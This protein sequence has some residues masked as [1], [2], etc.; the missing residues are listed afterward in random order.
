MRIVPEPRPLDIDGP[1]RLAEVSDRFNEHPPV[2]ASA[3]R[4]GQVM[5][6]GDRIS[7]LCHVVEN[8]LGGSRPNTR[9]QME[10]AE[11]GDAVA[12]IFDEPQQRKHV[13]HMRSIEKL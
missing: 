3:R 5:E 6:G 2:L 12:R 4:R 13:L 7:G 1:F 10:D 8:P 9:Q 11:T